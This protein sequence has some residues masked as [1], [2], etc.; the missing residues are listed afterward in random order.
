MI[1]LIAPPR[2]EETTLGAEYVRYCLFSPRRLVLAMWTTVMSL[3]EMKC[4]AA[5]ADIASL[6]SLVASSFGYEDANNAAENV[7]SRIKEIAADLRQQY[8][9]ISQNILQNDGDESEITAIVQKVTGA[10]TSGFT[11]NVG[12]VGEEVQEDWD[13]ELEKDLNIV[14]ERC[15]DVH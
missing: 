12:D 13:A 1:G 9:D 3:G 10:S 14:I 6:T 5:A 8:D 7:R 15:C 2:S 11:Y 4:F